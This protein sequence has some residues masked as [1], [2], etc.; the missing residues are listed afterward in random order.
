V[1]AVPSA[2]R[3]RHGRHR[4]ARRRLRLPTAL[5]G[6]T[7]VLAVALGGGADTSSGASAACGSASAAV[8]Y[9]VDNRIARAIYAKELSGPEVKTDLA[10][11][12]TA[13]DLISAVANDNASAALAATTRIVYTQGWH[14]VRLRVLDSAG[15]VLADVGGPRVLGPVA[16]K[17]VSNGT[18]VGTFLMSVQDDRGYR[19]LVSQLVGIPIVVYQD[20]KSVTASISH[21]PSSPPTSAT[22]HL[23]GSD[24]E[25]DG[26]NVTAFPSGQLR[27]VVLIPMPSPALAATSCAHVRLVTVADVVA[28][29]AFGVDGSG[30]PFLQN[31]ST[32]VGAV[33]E[34]VQA[35]IP[36]FVFSGSKE[37]AGSNELI[38]SNY[39]RP[40]KNLPRGGTVTYHSEHWLVYSLEPYPP[41]RIYV[42][43]PA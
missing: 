27:V 24:Y 16:G 37:V 8:R 10:H 18:V 41:D 43:Q 33:V 1:S 30:F 17:L 35:P 15:R 21:P 4:A 39:P 13:S 34:Y 31:P 22:L 7:A 32:F 6:V 3:D 42:L 40:P 12:D 14:I 5:L 28:N 26:Y 2:G 11:V 23:G 38:G 29:I 36:V 9:A 19:K 20:G 25:V